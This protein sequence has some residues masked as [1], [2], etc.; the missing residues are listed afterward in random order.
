PYTTLFRSVL[1]QLRRR[2]Q[3]HNA[4][5]F[6]LALGQTIPDLELDRLALE[7]AD[8]DAVIV[9]EHLIAALRRA[10]LIDHLTLY[11]ELRF[12]AE[13][14]GELFTDGYERHRHAA[15]EVAALI[16]RRL[17]RQ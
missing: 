10:R 4:D 6:V 2:L 14:G 11:L 9:L 7:T 13:A 1:A 15:D 16:H 3:Q 12:D 17:A 8:Q 5:A